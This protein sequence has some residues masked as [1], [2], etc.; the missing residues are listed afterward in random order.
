MHQFDKVEIVQLET[1]ER[2]YATLETMVSHVE[3]L[4]QK[5]ELPY[6]V[7]RL[8]NG[9]TGFSARQTLDIEVWLPGQNDGEGSF[10]EISSCSNCGLFQARRMKARTRAEGEKETAFVHTLN[11]SALALG[12]CMIALLEN[13]QQEDGSILLPAALH[14]YMGTDRLVASL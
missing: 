4:L 7:L 5:L 10:R 12:R 8:C 3:G 14:S 6:R 1:P 13:G 11:G 2:S 9:D